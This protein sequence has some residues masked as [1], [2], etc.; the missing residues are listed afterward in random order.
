MNH[1]TSTRCGGKKLLSTALALVLLVSAMALVLTG[2]A[3]SST[4][5]PKESLMP[6]YNT[7]KEKTM[8]IANGSLLEDTVSDEVE[9]V[10]ASLSG[11]IQVLL[12]ENG[13]LYLYYDETVTQ[14]KKKNIESALVS[15][16]GKTFAYVNSKDELYL[17]NVKD[18]EAVKIAEN[19]AGDYCLSPDGKS[20]LYTAET[21]DGVTMFLYLNE[22]STKIGRGLKPYGLSNDADYIYYENI[23]KKMTYAHKNGEDAYCLLKKGDLFYRFNA[24]NTQILF[25]ADGED[26]YISVEA[27]KKTKISD[28]GLTDFGNGEQLGI[29][30]TNQT[31]PIES[32]AEQVILTEEALLYINKDFEVSEIEKD[33][34][35]YMTSISG[36]VVY[37]TN[38]DGA[39][40]CGKSDGEEFEKVAKSV[41]SYAVTPDGKA[42]YYIDGKEN[43][44]YAKGTDEAVK[45]A[46]KAYFVTVTQDGYA[47]FLTDL[48]E[49]TYSGTL[50]SAK[51][52]KVTEDVLKD[53]TV[54]SCTADGLAY[55]V[56]A[57]MEKEELDLY[58]AT[59]KDKFEALLEKF[60]FPNN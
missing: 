15:A 21:D 37:F 27:G 32:F 29:Q 55:A 54:V 14:I 26:Y 3:G 43:L 17:Y 2:C 40:Y 50:N 16:D 23:G 53:V 34:D 20:I 9:I 11:D 47:L 51:K 25:S 12:S 60:P 56:S 33:V 10:S 24:D 18:E 4:I 49:E 7:E 28:Q 52:D 36:D 46:K 48:N 31:L 38:D 57:D 42:C 58:V 44:Y 30:A 39:L 1:S 35:S 6:V 5:L 59:K 45:I 22:E 13:A 19:F 41:E 8:F